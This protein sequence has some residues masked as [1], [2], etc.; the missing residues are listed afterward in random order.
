[1]IRN[2]CGSST[3]AGVAAMIVCAACRGP[4]VEQLKQQLVIDKAVDGTDLIN[5]LAQKPLAAKKTRIRVLARSDCVGQKEVLLEVE[6]FANTGSVTYAHY[7]TWVGKWGLAKITNLDP[8]CYSANYEIVPRQSVYW[9]AVGSGSG[10]VTTLITT[11]D[12]NSPIPEP[13]SMVLKQCGD[14]HSNL[15]DVSQPKR[16]NGASDKHKK[17][18]NHVVDPDESDPRATKDPRDPAYKEWVMWIA[19]GADCCYSEP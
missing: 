10:T 14:G 11:T 4:N 18:C 13:Q 8:T 1:M 3:I 2:R 19:C 15:G 17:V 7:S 16:F 12:P 5:A 9:Y 6:A